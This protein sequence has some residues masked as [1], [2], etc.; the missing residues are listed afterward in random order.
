[1][2]NDPDEPVSSEPKEALD[3]DAASLSARLMA[4][5]G[6]SDVY[7]YSAPVVPLTP[8]V[9]PKVKRQRRFIAGVVG[10]ILFG[11]GVFAGTRL[12]RRKISP[13]IAI[14][15]GEAIT[16]E[17]F[18][19][20]S[21]IPAGKAALQHLIDD[22]LVYQFA[23]KKGVVPDS[24][25]FT[26]RYA[27]AEKMP[28][29]PARLKAANQTEEDFKK[30]LMFVLCR[31]AIVD[32]GIKVNP[33]EVKAYYDKN[34]DPANPTAKYYHKENITIL[35]VINQDP[36]VIAQAKKEI[37][38]K[39]PFATVVAKYSSDVSKRNGGQLPVI[40]RGT[41]DKIKNPNLEKTLFDM[42]IGQVSDTLVVSKTYWIVLC[43]NKNPI[44]IDPFEKVENDCTFALQYEKGLKKNGIS[45]KKEEDEF[46]KQSKIVITNPQYSDV[47]PNH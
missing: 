43:V 7:T 15:N 18:A 26:A 9:K 25:V 14:V 13:N 3:S 22:R 28:S 10:I 17:E 16:A 45:L 42:Q 24:K 33:S 36:K 4:L 44:I 5:K 40:V 31:Q 35:A 27:E 8:I 38:A 41:I 19:H 46:I 47:A 12:E 21:E 29:F 37:E 34:I 39:V 30:A 2:P 1:M 20:A 11:G 32:E 23:K 6:D